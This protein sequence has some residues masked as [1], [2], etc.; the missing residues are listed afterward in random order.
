[1][2]RIS[3]GVT[4]ATAGVR[5]LEEALGLADGKA[6]Q[7]GRIRL[8]AEEAKALQEVE[9]RMRDTKRQRNRAAQQAA[10]TAKEQRAL[11]LT[12]GQVS[13]LDPAARTFRSVGKMYML[14][15]PTEIAADLT[16]KLAKAKHKM[17][18]CESTLEY[19]GRTERDV[20]GAYAELVRGFKSK[21]G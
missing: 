7:P 12:L 9:Q 20:E 19:L 1:M 21:R 4:D 3:P 17:R 8:T 15:P 13:N 2:L 10:A 6:G 11:E 14:T 16:D 5:R 18:V